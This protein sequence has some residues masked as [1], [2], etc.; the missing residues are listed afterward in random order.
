MAVK[1]MHLSVQCDAPDLNQRLAAA[2]HSLHHDAG[3]MAQAGNGALGGSK[4]LE[5]IMPGQTSR[6]RPPSLHSLEREQLLLRAVD[7]VEV[8]CFHRQL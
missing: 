1:D 4:P 3:P 5:P 6:A 8:C 2:T 7:D